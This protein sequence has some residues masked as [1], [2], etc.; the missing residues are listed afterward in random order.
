MRSGIFLVSL[1]SFK[2]KIPLPSG[3][4]S[5]TSRTIGAWEDL[6]IRIVIVVYKSRHRVLERSI[7]IWSP[8]GKMV[9]IPKPG[10]YK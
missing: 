1:H 4:G 9:Q 6:F 7:K 8:D 5:W 10:Y 3:R 2:L